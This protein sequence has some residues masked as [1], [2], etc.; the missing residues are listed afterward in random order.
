MSG[1][2]DCRVIANDR[3]EAPSQSKAVDAVIKE[4]GIDLKVWEIDKFEVTK[5]DM[6]RKA[7]N[8]HIATVIGSVSMHWVSLKW[9]EKGKRKIGAS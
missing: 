6:G 9:L 4:A 8:I 1:S 7:R 2:E 5:W 3:V